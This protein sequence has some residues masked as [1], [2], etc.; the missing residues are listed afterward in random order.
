[1]SSAQGR[2]KIAFVAEVSP[3]EPGL[4]LRR[5][6]RVGGR[7]SGRTS[8][9]CQCRLP[10]GW[11]HRAAPRQRCRGVLLSGVGSSPLAGPTGT[12]RKPLGVGRPQQSH[13][14]PPVP[15]TAVGA[16]RR[17]EPTRAAPARLLRRPQ[18]AGVLPP[19]HVAGAA[20]KQRSRCQ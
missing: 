6:A 8:G 10:A 13:G 2:S 1:M 17:T 5:V 12:A 14:C 15:H 7:S 20:H 11:D 18:R 16:V 19:P 9:P 3:V 4:Y